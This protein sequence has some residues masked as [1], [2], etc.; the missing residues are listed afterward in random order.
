[1]A[2]SGPGPNQEP[3]T[4]YGCSMWVAGAQAIGLSFAASSGV[5]SES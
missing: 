3:G 4:P 2:R 5:V 1:M